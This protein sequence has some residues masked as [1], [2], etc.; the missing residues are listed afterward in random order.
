MC[1]TKVY[2][3]LC[4]CIPTSLSTFVRWLRNDMAYCSSASETSL[5]KLLITLSF[6]STIRS[7]VWLNISRSFFSSLDLASLNIL[8]HWWCSLLRLN[9]EAFSSLANFSY[10]IQI[11]WLGVISRVVATYIV[12]AD[13]SPWW[14]W[15]KVIYLEISNKHILLLFAHLFLGQPLL[16]QVEH[17]L[18]LCHLSQLSWSFLWHCN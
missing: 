4:K 2:T 16:F 15:H 9:L 14:L 6:L 3:I 10:K 1:D 13:L 11:H 18:L 8:R 5:A 12:S 17:S 7:N